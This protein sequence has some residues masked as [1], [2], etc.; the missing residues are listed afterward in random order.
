MGTF[1]QAWACCPVMVT[2]LKLQ[3]CHRNTCA[4]L[5]MVMVV[6]NV[7]GTPVLQGLGMVMVNVI[8][9]PMLQARVW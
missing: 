3:S 4:G 5:G 8:G 7:I 9:K 6:V 1:L 2:V